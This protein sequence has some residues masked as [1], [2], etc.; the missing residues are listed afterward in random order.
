MKQGI[1][2]TSFLLAAAVFTAAPAASTE[3]TV[4]V[5]VDPSGSGARASALQLNVTGSPLA[6][7][8]SVALDGTQTQYV[9]TSIHPINPPPPPC[10]QAST[11]QIACPTA[12]FVSISASLGAGDDSFS[13]GASVRIPASLSG[14]PGNDT[15]R[16]GSGADTLAGGAGADRLFGNNG[17]D[18]LK[19][20]KGNDVLF[21]GKGN[22][23]L[24]G[25]PGRDRLHG[26]PG[27]N[28]ERQ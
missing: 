22:D 14:G 9:V 26:G 3:P 28:I 20:G 16:G 1:A 10:T 25:G 2:L 12:D 18:T 17:S 27:H 8:I 11:F 15:L 21:G 5:S 13:V 19:G 23:T 7:Q 6:D 4:S 24:I